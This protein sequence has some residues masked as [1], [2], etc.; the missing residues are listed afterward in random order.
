MSRFRKS[1]LFG[2]LIAIV[3]VMASFLDLVHDLEENAG[4]DL[5]FKLRGLKPAP[6]EVVL[7]SIDRESSERLSL[8]DNPERWPR[9]LHARLIETLAKGGASVIIFDLYFVDPR[10]A[11]EDDLLA[12]AIRS[13]GNVVLAEPLK[14]RDIPAAKLAG[15][16]TAEHR[17]VETVKPIAPISRAA[18]A[19]APFVLP[20][21]P[22]KINQYWAFQTAAGDSPTFPVVAFQ[23]YTLPAYNEFF[24]LLKTVDPSAAER[25]PNSS[26]AFR[27]GGA[28]RLIREIR[29]L[30]ERDPS[31]ARRL[32]DELKRSGLSV[33][34]PSKAALIESLIGMYGGPDHRYLNYYGPPRSLRTVP[35]H[36]VLQSGE[37]SSGEA[38]LD[39]NGKAVFVGL[40]E[41]ALTEKKD[42]FYTTFS[43]ADGVFLSGAEIA[44]TAFSNLLQNSP[45]TPV[46]PPILV[47][48][49]V[50]WGF[51]IAGIGRMTST[52]A[53]VLTIVGVDLMYLFAA[54]FMFKAGGTWYPAIVPLFI[55]SPLALG[56]GALWNYFETNKERRNIRKALSYYV[57]D[58]VVDHLAANIAD[59]RRDDQTLYGACL[60]TDCEGYTTVSEKISARELNDFMRKYFAAIFE[61][62]RKNGGRIVG[63]KG[64]AVLAVW[65]GAQDDAAIRE[66]ACAAALGIAKA[67][68]RFND[69]LE[70][71]KLPTRIAVHAGEIFF[72]NIGAEDLYQYGIMGD[73][74]NTASRMDGLNKYLGTEILVSDELLHNVKGFLTREAGTFLFKGKA[75]RIR[76]HELLAKAEESAAMQRNACAI[77]AEGLSAF[78]CHSWLQAK[79]KFQQ[80]ADLLDGDRLSGFYL[81]LFN[82]YKNHPPKE[83]WDGVV[84]LEEK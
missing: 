48:V 8:P 21:L 69:S 40:S 35:F 17:I 34:E 31:L 51:L 33:R 24:G 64:D 14:A 6:S 47:A 49:I 75:Q 60:F 63:L 82:R 20:K 83:P 76:V 16:L 78:R 41:F 39:F 12:E 84:E 66:Q 25:L 61:P 55:Q 9:S 11:A 15:I 18:F 77:F 52:P 54:V 79:E 22:V 65:R 56:G 43:R 50:C 53:A 27:G 5:L 1:I 29:A 80:S 26:T 71:F 10:S 67:V 19:S 37:V 73:T 42:S 2:L 36:Q 4:L 28:L 68:R 13:A 70:N 32:S 58:E 38:P 59:V 72:G 57:P 23:L 46:S 45:V 30:F 81:D 74:V 62:V 3:G 44:A 7:I